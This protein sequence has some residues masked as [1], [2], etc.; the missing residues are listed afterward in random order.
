MHSGDFEINVGADAYADEEPE[1]EAPRRA[2]EV[3]AEEPDADD[4]IEDEIEEEEDETVEAEAKPRRSAAAADADGDER[5]GRRRRGRRGGRSRRDGEKAAA[6]EG[7]EAEATP[8]AADAAE[9]TE[10]S[11]RNERS[12]E[13]NGRN[14]KRRR[15]GRG[16]GRRVYEV[17]GGEWLDFVGADLKSLSPR[18]EPRH[19]NGDAR[20][21]AVIADAE[22]EA[23]A[24]IE[25]AI[26]AEVIAHPAAA[27]AY[28]PEP[29][30]Q[31]AVAALVEA[32]TVESAAGRYDAEAALNYEPDQE[33]RDKFL[34][35]FSRWGKKG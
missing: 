6:R 19:R 32:D 24:E 2:R 31:E 29:A 20:V 21:Q 16:R 14:N 35:R 12:G 15:R 9:R 26:E 13:R 1:T 18:A 23:D 17:D 30:Y 7:D 11:E 5:R 34:S 33:R 25:A 10:R 22:A 8:V 27:P 28:E 3:V 4:L